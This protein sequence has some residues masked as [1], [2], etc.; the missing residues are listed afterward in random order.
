MA[1]KRRLG[2]LAGDVHKVNASGH[3][4]GQSSVEGANLGVDVGEERESRP[5]PNLHDERVIH[6]L[7]FE[8]HRPRSTQESCVLTREIS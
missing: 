6:A 8:R 7:E 2:G 4:A 1:G 3:L 5:S